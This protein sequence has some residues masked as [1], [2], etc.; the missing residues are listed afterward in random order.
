MKAKYKTTTVTIV[1]L[2][3]EG[4]EEILKKAVGVRPDADVKWDIYVNPDSVKATIT[5]E[6][7]IV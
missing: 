1:T 4:I 7:I 6:E 3:I 5:S 2:S